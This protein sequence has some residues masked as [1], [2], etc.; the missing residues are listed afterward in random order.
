M[1]IWLISETAACNLLLLRKRKMPPRNPVRTER[2]LMVVPSCRKK[3]RVAVHFPSEARLWDSAALPPRA[4][5]CRRTADWKTPAWALCALCQSEA[6]KE[7]KKKSTIVESGCCVKQKCRSLSA[8]VALYYKDIKP[9]G[10]SWKVFAGREGFT[11]HRASL[12]GI[13]MICITMQC[14]LP[15][16]PR[17]QIPREN[18]LAA[19]PWQRR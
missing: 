2:G 9:G 14:C 7:R 4:G 15:W 17:C 12:L 19:W 16:T 18:T 8:L 11:R 10:D 1:I 13:G 3:R 5:V 6:K